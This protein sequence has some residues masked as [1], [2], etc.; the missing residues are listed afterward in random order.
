MTEPIVFLGPSLPLEDARAIFPAAYR[1]PA[2]M[3]DV[4]RALREDPPAIAII[5]GCF[6]SVPSVRHK[7][8]L[9]AL[10][11][12]VP[13]YGAAS[14]GAL[15][16]AD[17]AAYGT[18]GVG[19]VFRMY[20]AG[21]LEDD[22]EVAVTHGPAEVGYRPT[23]DAL[24]DIRAALTRA[25]D[26]GLIDATTQRML[27]GLAKQRHF[28][29]R[30]WPVLISEGAQAGLPVEQLKAL[31]AYIRDVRPSIKREDA[32]EL[33]TRMARDR[34]LGWPV[35]PDPIAVEPSEMLL[36]L[37]ADVARGS[38]EVSA[39]P[40]DRREAAMLFALTRAAVDSGAFATW[41]DA[42]QALCLPATGTWDSA[43]V[44]RLERSVHDVLASLEDGREDWINAFLPAARARR[45]A[46]P[47]RLRSNA[48]PWRP[49]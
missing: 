21:G 10:S 34:S 47:N 16:A 46:T 29:D 2:A 25:G 42:C 18:I 35:R 30:S 27:L 8:I 22:D 12:G 28:P 20:H 31:E 37:M 49:S 5:D 13:V 48:T 4:L 32:I 45:R 11:R 33:L 24:V 19:E 15:R 14:M 39:T 44:D 17:T 6:D 23:S 43:S 7:E 3:G 26:R 40:E 1:P 41:V 9:L 36:T 38:D